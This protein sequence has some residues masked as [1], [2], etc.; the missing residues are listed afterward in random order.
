MR[1]VGIFRVARD[2]VAADGVAGR[3]GVHLRL[4]DRIKYSSIGIRHQE[5]NVAIGRR[6]GDFVIVNPQT[7]E[8]TSLGACIR[9]LRWDQPPWLKGRGRGAQRPQM[10][11]RMSREWAYYVHTYPTIL[12]KGRPGAKQQGSNQDSGES[13]EGTLLTCE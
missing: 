4:Q 10:Q 11:A 12:S 6:S 13:H 9:R 1:G 7:V 2:H 3:V 5:A 8:S